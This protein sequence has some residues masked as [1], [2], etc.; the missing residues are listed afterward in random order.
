RW[1]GERGDGPAAAIDDY[2]ALHAWS[3]DQPTA[4]WGGLIDWLGVIGRFEGTKA[5]DTLEMPGTRWFAG[6]E[7]NYAENLLREAV[8]G[9]PDRI[10]ITALSE[11]REPIALSYG[12][13]F[14][15]VGAFE[16]FLRSLGVTVGDR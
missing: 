15:R 3:V 11:A 13:L 12:E 14:S 5:L 10:A 4:F 8:T 6:A 9:D 7:F 2:H 1:L 16:A